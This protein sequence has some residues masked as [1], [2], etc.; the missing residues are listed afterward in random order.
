MDLKKNKKPEQRYLEA[1][2]FAVKAFWRSGGG[3]PHPENEAGNARIFTLIELL[4]VIA[5]IAILAAMLF[6]A[7]N[8]AR[9]SAR[10]TSCMND[11]R[12]IHTA[13]AMYV[14][15][16]KEW[17]PSNPGG[18]Y[19]M[20]K[21]TPYLNGTKVYTSC[22]LSNVADSVLPGYGDGY[23]GTRNISFGASIYTLPMSSY[24]KYVDITQ[25]SRKI[26]FGD[27]QTSKQ[28]SSTLSNNAAIISYAGYYLP[29]YRHSGEANFIFVDGHTRS[30]KKIWGS[31]MLSYYAHFVGIG[32][33]LSGPPT[34][35]TYYD[36]FLI[37]NF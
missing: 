30:A 35:S 6:P 11:L 1:F 28:S 23:W 4:V 31:G 37:P 14:T 26:L 16:W 36:A 21:L 18:D 17:L 9:L 15:D 33:L 12:Q 27:S 34:S 22:R 5:I 13:F 8:K 32:H 2:P 10:K 29:D 24:R 3:T 19:Y 25:P 7:L 20:F